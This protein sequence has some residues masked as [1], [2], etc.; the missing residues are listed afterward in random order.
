[1]DDNAGKDSDVGGTAPGT[2]DS[3][4]T[5]SEPEPTTI[6]QKKPKPSETQAENVQLE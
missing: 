1:M 3:K 5:E 4:S 6:E 2:T